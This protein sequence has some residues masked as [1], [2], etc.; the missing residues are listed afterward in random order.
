MAASGSGRGGAS[1]LQLEAGDGVGTLYSYRSQ[2]ALPPGLRRVTAR[3]SSRRSDLT[4]AELL[5]LPREPFDDSSGSTGEVF[6]PMANRRFDMTEYTR[7]LFKANWQLGEP[8]KLKGVRHNLFMIPFGFLY[9]LHAPSPHMVNYFA[10]SEFNGW[11]VGEKRL[12]LFKESLIEAGD[13]VLG[14]GYRL[15][16]GFSFVDLVPYHTDR[17]PKPFSYKHP[18]TDVNPHIRVKQTT[19][20]IPPHAAETVEGKKAERRAWVEAKVDELKNP[21]AADGQGSGGDQSGWLF[22]N[23]FLL[24]FVDTGACEPEDAVLAAKLRSSHVVYSPPSHAD[25]SALCF[26]EC[27]AEWEQRQTVRVGVKRKSGRN[28]KRRAIEVRTAVGFDEDAVGIC[29]LDAIAERMGKCFTVINTE[30]HILYQTDSSLSPSVISEEHILLGLVSGHWVLPKSYT[31]FVFLRVKCNVCQREFETE[32]RLEEHMAENECLICSKCGEYFP[33]REVKSRHMTECRESER[34]VWMKPPERNEYTREQM[35]ILICDME[36]IA[37]RDTGKQ[38]PYA[39]GIFDPKIHREPVIMYG[40]GTCLFQ[41]K[42]YF[43]ELVE[44]RHQEVFVALLELFDQRIVDLLTKPNATRNLRK[45][46]RSLQ[47]R[48]KKSTMRCPI[49]NTYM[50]EVEIAEHTRLEL[51]AT[52][53]QHT[54][55]AKYWAQV[56]VESEIRFNKLGTCPPIV[57][58]AHNGGGYDWLLFFNYLLVN[59]YIGSCKPL[60][61]G[62]RLL[63]LRYKDCISLK[64]TVRLGLMGSLD[65]LAKGYGAEV[66]KWQAFPY[67]LIDCV[68]ATWSVFRKDEVDR[69]HLQVTD[70]QGGNKFKRAMTEEEFDEFFAERNDEF[71]V[72]QETCAYLIADVMALYHVTEAYWRG[73]LEMEPPLRTHPACY[74]TA[75]QMAFDHFMSRFMEP[76]TL[77]CLSSAETLALRDAVYGGCVEVYRHYLEQ[78]PKPANDLTPDELWKGFIRY[79][80]I[81]SS[82]PATMLGILPIG[83]PTLDIA[84]GEQLLADVREENVEA[85]GHVVNE[86]QPDELLVM[87]LEAVSM[88]NEEWC[89][90]VCADFQ[91]PQDLYLP[92]LPERRKMPFS[93]ATKTMFTLWPKQRHVY[94]A[95]EIRLAL[96]KG[97]RITRVY[98][99]MRFTAGYPFRSFIETMRIQKYDADGKDAN[100]VQLWQC[101]DCEA[102]TACPEPQCQ[103][104]QSENVVKK[105]KNEPKRT[106]AKLN[107]N[108]TFGKSG[109]KNKPSSKVVDDSDELAQMMQSVT[110]ETGTIKTTLLH[111]SDVG[112]VLLVEVEFFN[113]AP[114]KCANVALCASILSGGRNSLYAIKDEVIEDNGKDAIAYCD[115]DSVVWIGSQP[116][117]YRLHAVRLGALAGEHKDDSKV[118]A[119]VFAGPKTYAF[120]LEGGEKIAGKGINSAHN[121]AAANGLTELIPRT[122]MM[123]DSRTGE[124]RLA[125]AEASA[126]VEGLVGTGFHVLKQLVMEGG[127]STTNSA[128]ML[129][130]VDKSLTLCITERKIQAAGNDKRVRLDNGLFT[131]RPWCVLDSLVCVEQPAELVEDVEMS[132]EED[133]Q[134]CGH[135]IQ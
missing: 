116:R 112:A 133:S 77:A 109:Q 125:G 110:P 3:F 17:N 42:T 129:K 25:E 13:S 70:E 123:R 132:E 46:Q 20:E 100:G 71:D 83:L 37:N 97:Y 80:D 47:G 95:E 60:F 11:R 51:D 50:T 16:M 74:I 119:G 117:S 35:R 94:Y 102:E 113:G 5:D 104:C 62:G 48:I 53:W 8:V 85:L 58:L 18:S 15:A 44:E 31:S 4:P 73:W 43:D 91:A 96:S 105:P 54:C 26:W 2:V 79:Y 78:D 81:N 127:T 65:S 12:E 59:D 29:D 90:F 36:S 87:A 41:L 1:I 7:L 130:G 75:S 76:E 128:T 134:I 82:Y 28:H 49:C 64:D 6:E 72:H 68:E 66:Q 63:E 93:A 30:R 89:G 124:I 118:L 40:L 107:M 121:W 22:V 114:P 84:T 19:Y 32:D 57:V 115:T 108:S 67:S 39:V 14:K 55:T 99:T 27:L 61:Q 34:Q 10:E 98:W 135:I 111:E 106:A 24:V 23:A 21:P 126:A 103:Q 9:N 33:S 45:I 69:Y 88:S 122:M 120:L 56:R 86:R 131:T 38:E 101:Q 92:V 52:T